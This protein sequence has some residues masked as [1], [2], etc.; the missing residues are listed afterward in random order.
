MHMRIDQTGAD[1]LPT[2]IVSLSIGVDFGSIFNR[3]DLSIL[4]LD[5]LLPWHH[6]PLYR[7][8]DSSVDHVKRVRISLLPWLDCEIREP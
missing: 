1:K 6:F 4:H 7:I 8:D 3:D 2:S 5:R